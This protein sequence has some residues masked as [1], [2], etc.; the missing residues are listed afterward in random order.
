MNI[1]FD[2]EFTGVHKDTTLIS[3][4]CVTENGQTF[5]AEFRDY[6][7]SKCDNWITENV[8]SKLRLVNDESIPEIASIHENDTSLSVCGDTAYI[9]KEFK[10]WL[11]NF[12]SVQF[13]TDVGHYDFVLLIDLFGTAFDL[14]ANVSP[15]YHDINQ[16]I[17]LIGNISDRDAFNISRKELLLNI[18]NKVC[19]HNALDDAL[20]VKDIYEQINDYMATFR[21]AAER[22]VPANKDFDGDVM[23]IFGMKIASI[24]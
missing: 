22:V 18:T 7:R 14:P 23:N 5:Y 9:R 6:D 11:S 4:G 16:D 2:T 3:L 19:Q 15:C 8:I 10:R 12:D 20:M 24:V 17:A 1:Y 13:V 21:Y